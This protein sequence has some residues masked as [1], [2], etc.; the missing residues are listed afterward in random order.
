MKRTIRRLALAFLAVT[1]VA[2]ATA[3]VQA[4]ETPKE[5]ARSKIAEFSWLTG[6]WRFEA[7]GAVWEDIWSAPEGDSLVAMS[8]WVQR[9]KTRLYELIVIEEE[10]DGMVLRLRHFSRGLGS[11]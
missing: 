7:E 10:E 9:G 3:L 4:Q 8:R 6:Y 2:L 1:V 11:V 5:P